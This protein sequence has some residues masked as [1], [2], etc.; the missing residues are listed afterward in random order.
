[1]PY[2]STALTICN[3]NGDVY[4][5]DRKIEDAIQANHAGQERSEVKRRTLFGMITKTAF[6]APVVASF[7]LDALS[8]DKAHA[9]GVANGSGLPPT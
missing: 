2:K 4:D 5:S 7:A 1:L 9:V 6:I 3:K 8:V